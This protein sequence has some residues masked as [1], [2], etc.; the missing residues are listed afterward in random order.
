MKTRDYIYFGLLVGFSCIFAIVF[1]LRLLP[2]DCGDINPPF[3]IEYATYL[4]ICFISLTLSITLVFFAVALSYGPATEHSRVW[5]GLGLA[6]ALFFASELLW[7][8]GIGPRYN[9]SSY[10]VAEFAFIL[11]HIPLFYGLAKQIQLSGRTSVNI[12]NELAFITS[13][14]SFI[15]ICYLI[16]VQFI[17]GQNIFEMSPLFFGVP[18]LDILAMILLGRVSSYMRGGRLA[19]PWFTMFSGS[20]ILALVDG[21]IQYTLLFSHL[22]EYMFTDL[23]Q[24]AALTVT[25]LAG[26]LCISLFREQDSMSLGL[27]K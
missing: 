23:L 13:M 20:A 7:S 25:A 11:A 27:S 12:R 4:D 5:F 19:V 8:Y 18:L 16:S 6:Y 10:S 21:W 1:F 17:A 22:T 9:L 14:V 2:A 24:V 15:M 26:I 3:C